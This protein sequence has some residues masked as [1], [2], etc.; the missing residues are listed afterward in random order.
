MTTPP[1]KQLDQFVVRLPDGM[2]DR[3]K[4]AA[5]HNNR[6]M[7]A[8]IVMALEYWLEAD[9][10][11]TLAL[12]AGADRGDARRV[13]MMDWEERNE[14]VTAAYQDEIDRSIDLLQQLRH[15]IKA[16][17]TRPQDDPRQPTFF[18]QVDGFG[19]GADATEGGGDPRN[20][21]SDD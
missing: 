10:P 7:N 13:A 5:E 2:R 17:A 11:Y 6:S 9:L 8:E 14:G 18:D 1:S 3:I 4:A 19:A 20:T 21:D 15:L 12:G 16:Q